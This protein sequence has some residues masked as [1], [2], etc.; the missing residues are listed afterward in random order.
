MHVNMTSQEDAI[1]ECDVGEDVAV[2]G[3]MGVR[4]QQIAVVDPRDAVFLCG[5]AIDGHAFAELVVIANDDLGRCPLDVGFVLGFAADDTV[6]REPVPLANRGPA[7]HCDMAVEAA[8]RS[9][10]DIG[11][12]EAERA[13]VDILAQL[14]AGIHVGQRRDVSCH[15]D[16]LV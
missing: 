10:P 13:N 6:L 14:S 12:D 8:I 7:N 5:P 15:P 9:D 3:H 1:H 4:H 16:V 2:V 11:A